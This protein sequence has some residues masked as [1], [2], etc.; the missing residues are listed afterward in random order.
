MF[1]CLR[2]ISCF[3]V[4]KAK[5]LSEVEFR[6]C[7]ERDLTPRFSSHN[8]F[9]QHCGYC[10]VCPVA[11]NGRPGSA[12]AAQVYLVHGQVLSRSHAKVSGASFIFLV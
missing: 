10:G 3:A 2:C 4:L 5:S 7:I 1:L 6:P 11:G 9:T 12:G 8:F